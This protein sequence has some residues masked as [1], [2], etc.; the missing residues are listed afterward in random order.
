MVSFELS[1]EQKGIQK[2]A[3]DFANQYIRPWA[4]EADLEPTPGKS[5]DWNIIRKGSE[6]GFR[7]LAVP[8]ELGGGGADLLTLC[9]VTEEFAAADPGLTVAFDQCWKFSHLLAE[10][11]GD[12]QRERWFPL[13]MDDPE[14]LLA[15]GIT[16][17]GHGSDN[18]G[19]VYGPKI[20]I[21]LEAKRDVDDWVLNGTKHYIANGN[22]AKIYFIIART[23]NA[24]GID[25]G[26]TSFIVAK[27]HPGFSFGRYHDKMGHRNEVNAELIFEN[28][29]IPDRDRVTPIGQGLKFQSDLAK[30][31]HVEAA[32]IALGIARRAFDES[33]EYARNRVQGGKPIAGHQSVQLMLS[34]MAM[35]VEASRNFVWRTAIRGEEEPFEPHYS[36][37]CKPFVAEAAFKCAKIGLEIWAGMG[38]MKEAPMEKIMRDAAGYLHSDGSNK[39]HLLKAAQFFC[40]L[41]QKH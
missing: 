26:C 41:T 15:I 24:V 25:E 34:E 7:T 9:L 29:R 13:F 22:I 11:I 37:L 35:L 38:Y 30:G 16:E 20:G 8:S 17:P 36:L 18:F 40:G 3:R 14:C 27:G 4:A 1:E 12:E 2:L 19:L 23:D 28:C 5:F 21:Q 6:L 39:V 32:A 31:S 10:S 33:L